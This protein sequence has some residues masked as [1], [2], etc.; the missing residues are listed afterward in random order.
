MRE[1]RDETRYERVGWNVKVKVMGRVLINAVVVLLVMILIGWE[2]EP[3]IA[4]TCSSDF[5]SV[6]NR[7]PI[8]NQSASLVSTII[9]DLAVVITV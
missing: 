7:V 8:D 4:I 3:R 1:R 6:L 9:M 5:H 2:K